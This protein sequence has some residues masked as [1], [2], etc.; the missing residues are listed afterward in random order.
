MPLKPFRPESY[1]DYSREENARALREW[2][3]RWKSRF[4]IRVPL[5][6]DGKEIFKEE[7][8]KDINPNDKSVIAEVSHASPEDVDRAVRVAYEKFPYWSNLP[9]EERAMVLI[10]AADIMRRRRLELVGLMVQEVGK[11][12][13]EADAD[14]AEAIDFCEYYAREMLDIERHIRGGLTYLPNEHN[15]YF[16]VPLGVVSVIPPWNFP[17]AITT[18]MTVAALVTGNTVVLKPAPDSAVLGYLLADIFREA[19]LPDGVLNIVQGDSIPGQAMV[20]HPL[21]RMIAFT[22]S[23]AVG[24]AIYEMGARVQPGQKWLKRVIAEMGGKD[25]VIVDNE[26]KIDDYLFNQII[27][28]AYGFQGQKCSATSRLIVVEDVYDDVVEGLVERVKKIEIGPAPENYYMGPVINEPSEQK[29]LHYIEIGKKEG[30]LVIGGGKADIGIDGYYI[31]PTIFVDV[32]PHAKIAQEEIFGPVLAV[33]KARDFDHAI[34]IAN[35]SEYGLTGSVFTLN[36]EKIAKA[37]REL[38]IGNLYFN[39]KS[40]GAIVGVHPFGGFRMSGT[41]AKAGGPDYLLYFLQ[42]KA[43]SEVIGW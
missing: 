8:F 26:A 4:P 39:R 20:K 27:A 31:Q 25:P 1:T 2:I 32:D 6:I 28:G 17:I 29:I 43:V 36:R 7:T 24:T 12:W 14:V 18:G 13:L 40:T 30:K 38:I 23:R 19:G 35:D 16:Y 34:E 5:V 37:K 33:I 22:G 41:D 15:E 3:E 42:G 11:N 9:R 21:V 10:K